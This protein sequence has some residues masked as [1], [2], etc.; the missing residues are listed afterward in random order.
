MSDFRKAFLFTVIP[1]VGLSVISMVG[2]FLPA[3]G[4]VWFVAIAYG[5]AALL[6]CIVFAIKRKTR[7]VAG[8]LAGIGIGIVSLGATCFANLSGFRL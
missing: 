4:Y 3:L 1:I 7:V 6:S 5:A 8:I 2:R